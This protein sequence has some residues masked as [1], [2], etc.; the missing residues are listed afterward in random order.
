MDFTLEIVN[1]SDTMPTN[2]REIEIFIL[3]YTLFRSLPV[4]GNEYLDIKMHIN[5]RP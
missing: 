5:D 3:S 4:F 2:K 1:M